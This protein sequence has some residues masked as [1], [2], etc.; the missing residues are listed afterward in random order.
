M[1]FLV[2]LGSIAQNGEFQKRCLVAFKTTCIKVTKESSNISNHTARVVAAIN[3]LN[4]LNRVDGQSIAEIVLTDPGMA[5]A[6]DFGQGNN[7]SAGG[8]FIG[9][10]AIQNYLD[11]SFNAIAGIIS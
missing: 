10:D 8:F 3:F 2:D 6:A 11:T 9:D 7:P 5:G 4:I 1:A